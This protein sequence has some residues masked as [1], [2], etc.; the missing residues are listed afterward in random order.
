[1][2]GNGNGQRDDH[3]SAP[4]DARLI[5]LRGVEKTYHT[6]AGDF[7]ALKGIDLTI[8]HGEFVAVVGRSGSGKTTLINM[9]TGIDRP[10]GGSI[11]VA[12]TAVHGL[13]ESQLATWRGVNVGV[14]FQF[15]QLLPTLTVLEN[16]MLPMGLCGLYEHSERIER[17]EYLL[18]LVGIVGETVNQLPSRLSGGQ[19]QR[20]AIARS[21]AN[22]PSIVV[23][24]EPTGNLDSRTAAR[25]MDLFESLVQQGKT[26][27]MV[28][29]DN[30]L[31][32][33]ATRTL[34]LAEGELLNEHLTRALPTLNHDLLLRAT[35]HL[36]F[37]AYQPGEAIILPNSR[38]DDFYIVID[39]QVDVLLENNG[40]TTL[41]D[42]L[43]PSQY[44]GEIALLNGGSR[45][46]L[47]RASESVPV[48]VAALGRDVFHEV[49]NASKDT[50]ANLRDVVQRRLNDQQHA[51]QDRSERNRGRSPDGWEDS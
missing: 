27:L 17:G 20:A 9:L 39:G 44:F 25:V 4:D 16:V 21:L 51:H 3:Q 40:Q 11:Y 15:F 12:E 46:A 33:R 1:M 49:V 34:T 32:A 38:P 50:L 43:G 41:L 26:V 42:R 13:S 18:S 28:T 36:Q 6:D 37:R 7:V 22:D 19:Q 24:D 47:V 45:T 30:D 2:V 29:H 5:D 10:S 8:D 14:V 48:R 35:R 23:T 31:A